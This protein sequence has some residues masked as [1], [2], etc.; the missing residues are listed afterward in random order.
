MTQEAAGSIVAGGELDRVSNLLRRTHGD[1]Q[2]TLSMQKANADY[3]SQISQSNLSISDQKGVGGS[4]SGSLTASTPFSGV[5]GTGASISTE[6]HL[7]YDATATDTDNFDANLRRVQ[8]VW[9][10]ADVAAD[11]TTN[12]WV[13]SQQQSGIAVSPDQR[14]DHF[15]DD[16]ALAIHSGVRGLVDQDLDRLK[17][18]TENQLTGAGRLDDSAPEENEIDMKELIRRSQDPRSSGSMK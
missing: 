8:Q 4:V 12:A 10:Q 3:L 11:A 6:G 17:T 16:K 13:A 1:G 14:Q 15:F 9:E 7:R 5:T 2:S 18:E